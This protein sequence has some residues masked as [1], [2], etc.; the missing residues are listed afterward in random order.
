MNF[1]NFFFI[2]LPFFILQNGLSANQK[3]I[4]FLELTKNCNQCNLKTKDLSGLNYPYL[5]LDNSD[6]NG[7]NIKHGYLFSSG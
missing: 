2:F 4:N 5:V 6:F 1:K 3:D 7:A